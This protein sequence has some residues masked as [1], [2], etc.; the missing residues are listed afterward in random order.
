MA[1][2][3]YIQAK[4]IRRLDRITDPVPVQRSRTEIAV[5]NH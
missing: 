2:Q 3:A 1:A 4:Q 5:D